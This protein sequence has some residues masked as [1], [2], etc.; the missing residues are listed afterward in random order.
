MPQIVTDKPCL[1][2][3]GAAVFALLLLL[4][5]SGLWL[6]ADA[7]D[8]LNTYNATPDLRGLVALLLLLAAGFG[9]I[10]FFT[11]QP[12]EA[13]VM[14]LFGDYVGTELASGLRWANP[15]LSRRTVSR[16]LQTH[17][18]PAIKVNDAAGNPIEIG[19]AIVWHV[20]DSAKAV[21][22]VD[23][24]KTYVMLQ[25]ETALRRI[26]GTH[27]YDHWNDRGHETASGEETLSLRD[28][29]DHIGEAL[30][31]DLRHRLQRA[32]LDVT[33]ARITHLAYAPEIAQAMLRRQQAA[34]VL[35]ARRTIV[36]GAV[37]LVREALSGLKEKDI[38]LDGERQ[39]AMVSN[40][41]VVLV[42]DKDAT[43]VINTGTLYG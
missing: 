40:M 29:G 19:A 25:A 12:N 24:H 7:L 9:A 14:T 16:R 22:E 39:A 11:V 31:A 41:L 17:H 35:A 6:G 13:K 36:H 28:G 3:P 23:D 34:A 1:T 26:A 43:P 21:L 33:D 32:G 10:G 20:V 38:E 37:E 5:L 4:A 30:M 8:R 27:P 18:I 15:L 42:A 2:F